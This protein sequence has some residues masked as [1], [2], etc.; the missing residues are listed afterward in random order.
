MVSAYSILFTLVLFSELNSH[1]LTVASPATKVEDGEIEQDGLSA[2]LGD[3]P[4]NEH[5]MVPPAYRGR[6]M[7][8]NS[9]RDED[10]NRKIIIVSDMR[11]RGR[12]TRGLN[13]VLTRSLPLLA[14]QKLSRAPAEYS[15][16]IDRRDTD[17]NMLRCM[18][19][20]VYRPCWESSNIP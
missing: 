6:L 1:L 16:K 12:G 2:L 9:I 10:G 3:D 5:A 19:G 18:I 8:D 11:Q 7:L 17:F 15:F 20:R 4:I 13:S 14:D